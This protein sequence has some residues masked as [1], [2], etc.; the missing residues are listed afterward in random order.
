MVCFAEPK[1]DEGSTILR[2]VR[3]DCGT[4]PQEVWSVKK[5]NEFEKEYSEYKRM[6]VGC[7]VHNPRTTALPRCCAPFGCV[8][9]QC[10]KTRLL[11]NF[12]ILGDFC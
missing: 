12:V 1:W 2:A 11:P 3:I 10:N 5:E 7:F 6:V 4:G 8:R 9:R